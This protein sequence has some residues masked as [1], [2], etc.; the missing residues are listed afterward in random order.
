MTSQ[1][2]HPGDGR[3]RNKK[4]STNFND[5]SLQPPILVLPT[6]DEPFRIE[7]DSSDYAT[8]A[9]LSQ[10]SKKDDKWHPVAFLS[11]SLN[12]VEC[13]YEIYDKEMLA[14][15]CALEGECAKKVATGMP[16]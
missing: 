12:T 16:K 14:I 9:V 11:K 5:G 1:E 10:L 7:A 3:S 13:N 6:D 4:P 15:I 2:I 8:G